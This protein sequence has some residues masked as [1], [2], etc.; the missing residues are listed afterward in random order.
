MKNKLNNFKF[1]FAV[2]TLFCIANTV[3]AGTSET[4][5]IPSTNSLIELSI[6]NNGENS[7]NAAQKKSI[8]EAAKIWAN[9]IKNPQQTATYVVVAD[10]N[11]DMAKNAMGLSN[12]TKVEGETLT[13]TF[14]NARI[15]GKT[16]VGTPDEK[17]ALVSVGLD[18]W[19][20]DTY[21]KPRALHHSDNTDF[22]TVI[23][24]E[25]EHTL[26]VRSS[27]EDGQFT[28][29]AIISNWDKNIAIYTGGVE[30]TVQPNTTVKADEGAPGD[31]DVLNNA[32]YIKGENAL[33]VL[34]DSNDLTTAINNIRNN[35]A[36]DGHGLVHYSASYSDTTKYPQR[37]AVFGLPLEGDGADF[38]HIELRN[39]LMSHQNY[40][41]WIT[42][43]EAELASI[44]DLGYD[45]D[46]RKHFGKSYYLNNLGSADSPI[47]N[48]NGYW[49]RNATGTA[50]LIGTPS[51][52]DYGIG[53][54]IYGDN[55]YI[56]QNADIMSVGAGVAGARIEGVGN[57]YTLNSGHKI[58]TDGSD[59]LGIAVTYGKN[60]KITVSANSEVTAKGDG[61]RAI[62]FDFGE[63]MLGNEIESQGSYAH[64]GMADEED[65]SGSSSGDEPGDSS[66]DSSGDEPGGSSGG[67]SGDSSDDESDDESGD[68]SGDE[69]S[70]KS[71]ELPLI[72][73]I[74]GPLV[75]TFDLNGS[76]EG[77]DAAIYI[78]RN[79]YV[80]E[81][82][83]N[84]GS[85]V[86]GDIISN[87]DSQ[88]IN[89]YAKV[90][91]AD[92]Q[93]KYTD[94]NFNNYD[95]DFEYNIIGS[96]VN[97]TL[98]MNV[99]GNLGLKNSNVSVYSLNNTGNINVKGVA[100]ISIQ[101]SNKSIEGDTG[102]INISDNAILGFNSNV[103]T[104][105]NSITLNN[106]SSL[107]L[108]N[109]K[110]VNTVFSNNVNINNNSNLFID[111]DLKNRS[112]DT[113]KTSANF[114]FQDD[115]KLTVSANI[116]NTNIETTA[117]KVEIP[118]ISSELGN[119]QLLSHILFNEK[120]V[121]TPIFK[122][123][124]AYSENDTMGGFIIAHGANNSYTTYNPAV[125]AGPV[126][127]QLGGF[128]TQ[129][130]SYDQAFM[131]MDMYMMMPSAQRTTMKMRNKIASLENARYD[132][133]KTMYDYNAG[134][135]RPYATFETVALHNGPNVR[136][137][138]YG[139]FFGG[140][141]SLK[142]LGHGWDGMW[143]AYIGYNGSHQSY[144]GVGIYQNGGTLG[145]T[146]M[147]YKGN[148]FLGGTIN[149]GANA[150]DASTMYGN[151]EFAMLMSGAAIKTGYNWEL[152]SGKFII[153]PSLMT[154]YSFVNTFDYTNA[155]GVRM[156][157][158]PLHAITIEPG[159]KFIGNLKN[160]WQP[161]AG[162]SFVYNIMDRTRFHANDISLP[163]FSINPFVRYGV[164]VRK[165]WGDRLTGHFQT[166]FTNGGRNG[167]GLSAGFRWAI[168]K[169][170]SGETKGQTPELKSTNISL[171]NHK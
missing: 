162:V 68:E 38:G 114:N 117:D 9:V 48:N 41:N 147:A 35:V 128:A 21:I 10:P 30:K 78:S 2:I 52:A 46:L 31:F 3:K 43:M 73:D 112:T 146:G 169:N 138:M 106:N 155:A 72:E 99:N 150:G 5:Y 88:Y 34:G 69:S 1:L 90:K 49:E 45:I 27:L 23:V 57:T 13:M 82:N 163:N 29:P 7:F 83:I 55:N 139:S 16:I 108:A 76:V 156:D 140:E 51:T 153:Q 118:F 22:T 170:S 59:S 26:G 75:K 33:K 134:W 105:K 104:I 107:S 124:L 79:A 143:G 84:N 93:T 4:Y 12:L 15:L 164:G 133:T 25:I 100:N 94:L 122:Y 168:G 95:K 32:P 67:S 132:D 171:N 151:E 137:N 81:I 115:S 123:N 152:A 50:Y 101:D 6:I 96:K 135:F 160:G 89:K 86:K 159:I 87:W 166:Y 18:D 8:I 58:N 129:L 103:Q 121:L 130:N 63:N 102:S 161:Y 144:D 17:D 11:P 158:D 77:K 157:S 142:D 92:G 154:S 47:Q 20:L 36:G 136:N 120:D 66:G 98:K 60:H 19:I 53:L 39:N 85:T 14:V 116:L 37:P 145:L 70:E 24:H 141:S 149:V 91:P 165:T 64:Y 44:K 71:Q 40:R 42:F 62:S 126:A 111:M 65:S 97:N 119:T 125:L 127:T 54:H 131:N 61:G 28:F 148:Y 74:N 167:V 110:T 56:N 113:I 109:N 80:E